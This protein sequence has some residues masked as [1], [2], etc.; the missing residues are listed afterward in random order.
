MAF[1]DPL[2]AAPGRHTVRLERGWAAVFLELFPGAPF[3]VVGLFHRSRFKEVVD[4][5]SEVAWLARALS[6]R[7]G[8]PAI[9]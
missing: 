1:K 6:T 7:P 4:D 3:A 9:L 8:A 2:P 5:P